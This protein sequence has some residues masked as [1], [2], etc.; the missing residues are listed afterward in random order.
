MPHYTSEH[1]VISAE[2][3]LETMVEKARMD[4]AIMLLYEAGSG[5]IKRHTLKRLSQGV[6]DWYG[7]P[8]F[9]VIVENDAD[10]EEVVKALEE[11]YKHVHR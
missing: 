3:F 9:R 7:A 2:K 8:C 1:K 4:I 5:L 10:L 11:A 6:Q